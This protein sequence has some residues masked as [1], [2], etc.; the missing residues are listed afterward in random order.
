MEKD[1]HTVYASKPQW[2][3]LQWLYYYPE[4][5]I[6]WNDMFDN[7]VTWS[8]SWAS[9]EA[10]LN[11]IS[12]SIAFGIT[13][14]NKITKPLAKPLIDKTPRCTFQTFKAILRENLICKHQAINTNGNYY[15]LSLATRRRLEAAPR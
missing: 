3:V 4:V 12:V 8:A 13:G 5:Y 6:C 15:Q 2:D 11:M 1:T 14:I 9:R 7:H 10:K